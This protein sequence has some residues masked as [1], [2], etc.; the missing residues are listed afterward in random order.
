M[1]NRA[2]SRF[3]MAVALTGVVGPVGALL[4]GQARPS[5]L[6]GAARGEWVSYAA[7]VRGTRYMPL[8]QIDASNFS[9]LELAWRFSTHNLGPRPEFVLQGTPLMV[10]GTLYATGGGGNR[11]AVVAIDARTG[12]LLWKHGI[13][14][15]ARAD[16]APRR[17]SGRGLAYWTDGRGDER[18][19]YVTIGYRLVALSARTGQPMPSFGKEGIVD[20]KVGVV[21]HA[22][23]KP[24]QIDLETGEI[25]LHAAPTVAGNAIIVGSAFT[26]GL[27]YPR[28]SNTRGLARAFDVRTGKQLWKYDPF[29]KPGELGSDTWESDSLTYVG[30]MGVWAQITADEE[31]GLVYLPV[32][33]PTQDIYGGN[34]P[35]ANLFGET[36]VAVDLKT[37]RRKWHYQFTH[38]PIWD[39]DI[40]AAPIVADIVVDGKPI[41]AVAVPTKQS[42]LYVFDRI[43]GEPVWPIVEKPVPQSTVPGEK[44]SPTQPFPT[45]PPPYARNYLARDDLIDFTPEL[46]AEALKILERYNW[47]ETLF[48]PPVVGDVKGILG[49]VQ[50]GN[51]LGGTNWPGGGFDPES[52]I[53]FVHAAN[54]GVSAYSVMHRPDLGD[55]L[56]ISGV[57]GRKGGSALNLQGLPI[58]KPPYGVLA[59]I[60]LKTGD[61]KWQVP[62]GE[63]PDNIRNHKALQGLE[64]PRTG[65]NGSQ[66]LVVTKSLVILGD[67]LVTSPPGRERGAM[68][69]A[70]DKET[71]KEVGEV[72]M[73]AAQ[74]GSPMTYML[75]GRQYIVVAVGGPGA[76]AEYLAFRLRAPSKPPTQP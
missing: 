9:K 6:P 44:T 35:G 63:T 39:L 7:D 56:Y 34:R 32:E 60:D 25:G 31:A 70:Y 47:Q 62:H 43:T 59:A 58:V 72:L 64:I 71:G 52:Q 46:R 54:A 55:G 3:V 36:L 38:H 23:G 67:R 66:G 69:R 26:E 61:L 76:T 13:D 17:L 2:P 21:T 4:A 29:P 41:K 16:A 40:P 22:S 45:K 20:L 27:N 49:T 5:G 73:P 48:A 1:L 30:N 68:L 37:G 33:S 28:K 15:G 11:R 57:A 65:Q 8:D 14:E 12:E 51:T 74:T 10:G 18:I 50:V 53:V 42:M 19:L 75:D 24:E